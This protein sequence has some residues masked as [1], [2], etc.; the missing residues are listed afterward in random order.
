MTK[1]DPFEPEKLRLNGT[2]ATI[3]MARRT[4]PRHGTRER[5]LKGPIP[6]PWLEAAAGLPGKALHLALCLWQQAGWRRRRTVKLCLTRVGL[7]VS[8]Y[9][10][11]RALRLLEAAGLVSVERQPGHGLEVTLRDHVEES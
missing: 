8:E 6:W 9:A 10:G 5:F 4:P 3:P 7:G 2:A 1:F 11:R